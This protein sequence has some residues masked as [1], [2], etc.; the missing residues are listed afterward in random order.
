MGYIAPA[1]TGYGG[2]D[3]GEHLYT[4]VADDQQL[5]PLDRTGRPLP[6]PPRGDQYIDPYPASPPSFSTSELPAY[7]PPGYATGDQ[8]QPGYSDLALPHNRYGAQPG[9]VR[10]EEPTGDTKP[11]YA[12][13][14]GNGN[15]Y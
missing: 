4:A 1:S 3:S 12:N 2:P 15:G 9:S 8:A 13:G 14:Y 11:S 10:Y 6:P 7:A 5:I